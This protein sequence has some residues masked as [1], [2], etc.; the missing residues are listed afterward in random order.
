MVAKKVAIAIVVYHKVS[1]ILDEADEG[2]CL[3]LSYL[4]TCFCL[5]PLYYI[6]ELVDLHNT[7]PI[8]GGTGS[9]NPV[10]IVCRL[11]S[12]VVYFVNYVVPKC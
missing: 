8:G 6:E 12:F 3:M 5:W 9:K 2:K 10:L 4:S 1:F 11:L 7:K